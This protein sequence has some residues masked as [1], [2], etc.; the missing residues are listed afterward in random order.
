MNIAIRSVTLACI[1]VSNMSVVR[2][3]RG[4]F[5]RHL[6]GCHTSLLVCHPS[7]SAFEQLGESPPPEVLTLQSHDQEDPVSLL[8]SWFNSALRHQAL[9]NPHYVLKFIQITDAFQTAM[10]LENRVSITDAHSAR[11]LMVTQPAIQ[12]LMY[13]LSC[14]V[15]LT[16]SLIGRHSQRPMARRI[17]R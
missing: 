3:E 16:N 1:T 9:S 2:Q 10:V 5:L 13:V 7:S 8:V 14:I 12:Q 17:Q 4:P 15:F 6:G 11:D